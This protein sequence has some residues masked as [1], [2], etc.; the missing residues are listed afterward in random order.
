[1]HHDLH[2]I[3]DGLRAL[4]VFYAENYDTDANDQTNTIILPDSSAGLPQPQDPVPIDLRRG[5]FFVI[6]SNPIHVRGAVPLSLSSHSWRKVGSLGL[7]N[8]PVTFPL[9]Q[10]QQAERDTLT[11]DQLMRL[12]RGIT[13]YM[14][15]DTTVL[16]L[17][18]HPLPEPAPSPFCAHVRVLTVKVGEC[19]IRERV[20]E[21]EH[22]PSP[23]DA[24]LTLKK[25]R[26]DYCHMLLTSATNEQPLSYQAPTSALQDGLLVDLAV[27]M[28][29]MWFFGGFFGGV[30]RRVCGW[31]LFGPFLI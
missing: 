26:I 10:A 11:P 14:P 24:K 15:V 3:P 29:I 9:R 13:C 18:L 12:D 30:G 16:Y 17:L 5:N 22:L 7:A 31:Q 2:K 1:M 28:T 8:F 21:A 19:P 27:K 23:N 4:T 25:M 20:H 6:Y